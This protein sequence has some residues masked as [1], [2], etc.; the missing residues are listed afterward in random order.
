MGN[1]NT[2]GI[3]VAVALCS[4]CCCVSK[5]TLV[6]YELRVAR[7]KTIF[8]QTATWFKGVYFRAGQFR[9]DEKKKK[10]NVCTVFFDLV[11][12][13]F[14][15]VFALTSC[16]FDI[17][18][19]LFFFLWVSFTL[20][21]PFFHRDLAPSPSVICPSDQLTQSTPLNTCIKCLLLVSLVTNNG[22]SIFDHVSLAVQ[23]D[24][25]LAGCE[26]TSSFSPLC[27]H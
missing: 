12:W 26:Q 7:H 20:Q 9:L 23:D 4:R 6:C 16:W 17:C 3:V 14:L 5:F 11:W 8:L 24:A 10:H 15:N 18:Y 27:R 22:S 21:T 25:S 1:S 2:L 19:S 13:T